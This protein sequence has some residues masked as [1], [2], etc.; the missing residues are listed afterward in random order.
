MMFKELG[1]R[2]GRKMQERKSGSLCPRGRI[3]WSRK[4]KKGKKY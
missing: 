3:N 4:W 2:G 1:T